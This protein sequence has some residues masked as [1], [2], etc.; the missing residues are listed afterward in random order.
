MVMAMATGPQ[1]GSAWK[2]FRRQE[3]FL[4]SPYFEALFGGAKGPGKTDSLIANSMRQIEHPR[5]KALLLR[6]T[7]PKLQEILDRA[8]RIFPGYG[9]VWQGKASRWVFPSGAAIGFG[10][11]QREEDKYR[12]QGH[13][14]QYLGFDQVEEFT[15]TQYLFIMAQCRTSDGAV[16]CFVRATAN[17]GN[18][19]H[20]WVKNRFIDGADVNGLPRYF[21][22]VGDDEV[23]TTADDP[24]ALS[25][26]FVFSTLD[27][28]PALTINDPSYVTRLSLLP[29]SDY[30]A[31]RF[32]DW[33]AFSGQ[34]F[35]SWNERV[36]VIP[37]FDLTQPHTSFMALDYG[38][39]KPSSVGWYA[40]L[41]NKK[42]VRYREYY[43]EGHT[44]AELADIVLRMTPLNEKIDYCAADPAIWGDKQ[45]HF[46]AA[47][48][49]E[50]R[51]ESGAE[52]IQKIW[53]NRIP[54]IRADNR[55]IVGW[56]RVNSYLSCGPQSEPM[57]SVHKSCRAL[58]RTLPAM[59]H[60]STNVEDL[61]TAA[62]DH[63]VD[64]LRYAL[65]T[66]HIEPQLPQQER[67]PEEMFW[68][69]VDADR[70]RCAAQIDQEFGDDE[71]A[72]PITIED[73]DDI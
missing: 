73:A 67:T 50:A 9:A 61:D 72:V 3:I 5:Y 58:I 18:V 31:M 47:K 12:Y 40:A 43:K 15:L 42:I 44:Y 25:R 62:E 27:D 20:L 33:D 71:D 46:A 26:A 45:H 21:K 24:D 66:R 49:G 60:D 30:K 59:I 4:S 39:N 6:R 48:N 19:G 68:A 34:F 55:R 51:G 63:A 2:P 54:L 52:T 14:Y 16:R 32:G 56:G 10:H 37:D 17:P 38:Y 8:Y 13:E 36:H 1:A 69:M 28:N 53:G 11:C 65:M 64:E 23:Q 35:K 22:R 29:T 70:R 41:P 57:F 7:F